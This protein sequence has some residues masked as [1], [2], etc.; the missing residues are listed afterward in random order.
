MKALLRGCVGVSCLRRVVKIVVK[1]VCASLSLSVGVSC[2]R[3]FA[4]A[5]SKDAV[6]FAVEGEQRASSLLRMRGVDWTLLR[7]GAI[8]CRYACVRV[9]ERERMRE[10]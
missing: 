8:F 1:S 7:A 9:R 4:R 5:G 3:R 10:R 6:W 2:Q